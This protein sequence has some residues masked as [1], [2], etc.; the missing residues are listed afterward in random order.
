MLQVPAKRLVP[1]GDGPYVRATSRFEGKDVSGY[2]RVVTN[3]FGRVDGIA[4]I[5][6]Y[7]IDLYRLRICLVEFRAPEVAPGD[8]KLIW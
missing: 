6:R 7:G 2:G 8:A 4:W 3:C 5:D 1:K